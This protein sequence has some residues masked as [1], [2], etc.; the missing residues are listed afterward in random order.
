MSTLLA[1]STL[2]VPFARS[3]AVAALLG[4][5]FLATPMTAVFAADAPAAAPQTTSG[6]AAVDTQAETVEQRIATLHASLKITADEEANWKPVAQAMREN[7]AAM[8]KLSAAKTVQAP[9]AMSAIEDLKGYEA[10]AQ[11]HVDGLKN[12]ISSFETLYT[13][14]PDA[15]KKVADG[16]FQ[17]FGQKGH[18]SHS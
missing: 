9:Q 8:E 17:S 5:S 6:K 2:R 3:I 1:R 14:F 18:T 15:Q 7:A 4:A 10:F 12:L 11:A 16:V 13:A